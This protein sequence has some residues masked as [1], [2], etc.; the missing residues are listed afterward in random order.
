MGSQSDRLPTVVI[1]VLSR[2]IVFFSLS[3]EHQQLLESRAKAEE[4]E[5]MRQESA[6]TL[7]RL[8]TELEGARNQITRCM[9]ILN[10]LAGDGWMVTRRH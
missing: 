6:G 4:L 2:S 1:I 10:G 9:Y 8:E 3:A 7:V 5:E